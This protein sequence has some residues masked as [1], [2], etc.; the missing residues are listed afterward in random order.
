M[1]AGSMQIP[2]PSY[3]C[4][5]PSFYFRL[6]L[7][8][9]KTHGEG[10]GATKWQNREILKGKKVV[11]H[12]QVFGH[13]ISQFNPALPSVVWLLAPSCQQQDYLESRIVLL[14][15]WMEHEYLS[16]I[17]QMSSKT[18][19]NPVCIENQCLAWETHCSFTLEE[20]WLF[21]GKNLLVDWD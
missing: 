1:W 7:R 14:G 21:L 8:S 17:L 3:G 4:T 13:I 6:G 16:L 10:V 18:V 12:R 11:A 15:V 19:G 2:P 9:G 5:S 20:L